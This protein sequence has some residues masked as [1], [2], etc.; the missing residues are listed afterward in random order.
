MWKAMSWRVDPNWGEL[1][2]HVLVCPVLRAIGVCQTALIGGLNALDENC[3]SVSIP[4][5]DNG[6]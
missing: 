6:F 5:V 2:G 1:C 4:T 3:P